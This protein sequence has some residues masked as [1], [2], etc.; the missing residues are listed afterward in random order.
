MVWIC[1]ADGRATLFNKNWLQFTGQALH[2]ALG[3]GWVAAI[4]PD[5]VEARL[6]TQ[7][8]GLD[9]HAPFE[10]E[11]RLRRS[12]GEYRWMLDRAAPQFGTVGDFRGYVGTAIDITLRKS[13][14]DK[15][16]WLSKAVEQSPSIVTI[17]DLKGA[18]EYVNPKFTAVTG[19]TLEEAVGQNPR[20]LKSGETPPEEYRRLWETLQT[21]EW[22]GEFHNRRKNGEL[23]WER[24]SICAI[25][26]ESGKP[27]HYLAVKEDITEQKRVEDELRT[28]EKRFRFAVES[29]HLSVY[30]VDAR[31]GEGK[32]HGPDPFLQ[33]LRSWQEW[34]NALHPDDRARVLAAHQERA[35]SHGGSKE[36]YRLVDRKGVVRYYSDHGAPDVDGRWMGVLRDI[37]EE[38]KAEESLARLAGIVEC[39]ND[40]IIAL[41]TQGLL[42]KW[43]SAAEKLY[44]YK[45]EEVLGKAA[46]IVSPPE[47]HETAEQNI[48]TV[49]SGA[50]QPSY[51]TF[52]LRKNGQRVPV[53]IT[54]SP[55]R[56]RAGKVVGASVIVRDITER[57]HAEEAV[58]E[59]ENRFRAIVQNSTDI[60]TLIDPAGTI[61]YDSPGISGL[62]GFTPEERLG[63]PAFL[64]IH[65]DD[66]SFI[67]MLHEELLRTHGAKVRA[68]VRLR[69]ADESWRWCDSWAINLLEEPGVRAVV[70]SF[71]DITE[72]KAIETALRD[73]EERYRSLIENASDTIFT[74]DL[75]GN[76][77]SINGGGH[78]SGFSQP[79]LL[80]MNVLQ[81]AAPEY[82]E[83]IRE[84]LASRMRGVEQGTLEAELIA[85]D[86]RRVPMEVNGR[87]QFRNGVPFEVLCIARDISLRKRAERSENNRREVL[88]MVAQNQPLD[89]VLHRLEEMIGQS[90]PGV[91]ARILLPGESYAEAGPNLIHVP[92]KASDGSVL[93]NIEIEH[94]ENWEVTDLE[95]ILLDSKAKLAGVA[96]EHRQLTNRLAYQAHHDP[97]TGLPNRAMLDDRLRQAVALARRQVRQFA[98]VYVDL[99]RFKFINDTLG[100]HVGDMLL[101]EAA[102]RLAGAVRES[103]TLARPGGDEFVAVLFDIEQ[104][105]DAEM[106]CNRIIDAMRHPFQVMGH[107]LFVSASVGLS[108]Y[109]QDGEDAAT[110]QKHADVAMYEAKNQGRNRI[111]KFA[112]EMNSASLERLEIENDLHRALER[113]ELQLYYQPQ[114]QVQSRQIDGVEALL[115]W[116]HPKWGLVLPGRFVP[117]AEESGLIIPIS[118]WV[119]QEACRQHRVWKGAGYPPIRIAVNVSATQFTRSNLAEIVAEALAANEMEARYLEVE[120]TE[121]VLMRDVEDSRRQIA[122]LRALGVRISV[123]D[124]GT[125]YSSLSYLQRLAIDD[126]KI[127][128]CFVEGIG[129]A[130]ARQPLVQAIV[131]L[132]HG[133]H[134]TA[135]A[136]GVE[137]E[138]EMAVLCDLGC[139]R[140]QG[141][142]LGRPVPAG[143]LE[144]RWKQETLTSGPGSNSNPPA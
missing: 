107:E 11:Y 62:L 34:G 78:M 109:P 129:Q 116:N 41:D 144:G 65:P 40:A 64:W 111:Q 2:A 66:L 55:T 140:V 23:Y 15:L 43:N 38:K 31:T 115:R 32:I 87:L 71:R 67:R 56:D 100:H 143:Q 59:S 48:A 127:D 113:G 130:A 101:K 141:F 73:S 108:L 118:L 114:F 28:L 30:D 123:D 1:G 18:I 75:K 36:E 142:L 133:L 105:G 49:L 96:L 125:G 134:M 89:A 44:G 94:P 52:H 63:K 81:I 7:Q 21:G 103:D 54:A 139:D 85:R 93:G 74:T 86:G 29:A 39:S 95:R 70:S 117:V 122:D 120:L 80:G 25:R 10:T 4:H 60:L 50:F 88:E 132:A 135:T 57:K 6:A 20:I 51:E 24:A 77:T 33:S 124:F 12:D 110:L 128:R 119:L 126:L 136:E 8:A 58:R 42:Q 22:R 102:K 47:L 37:T 76:I 98:V 131:G 92:I 13:A 5:D 69:H 138:A 46:A 14:E 91:T 16:R 61:L 97:L 90:Y 17:T 112:R 79:E 84:S 35:M 26:D 99:D 53:S 19:Y 3:D 83:V 106:V 104:A 45:A 72:Q 68:Q 137:T 27:A 82:R 9:H 121:G